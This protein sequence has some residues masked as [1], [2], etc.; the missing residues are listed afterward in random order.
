MRVLVGLPVL[1]PLLLW[2]AGDQQP[3]FRAGISLVRLDV[4]VLA[5]GRPLQGLTREDFEIVDN[6]VP[7][8][9]EEVLG[10]EV[11]LD[12]AFV[13]DRSESVKGETLARLKEAA[14]ATF[15][16]LGERDR[17]ALLTFSD[18]M[19]LDA[20]LGTSRAAFAKAL[21]EVRGGGAT[22]L[23]D[24]LY[25]AV[26]LTELE[27]RRTLILLF[28]D[29]YDNRSWLTSAQ[30]V[31]AAKESEAVISAVALRPT[32]RGWGDRATAPLIEVLK[33]VCDTT[34]GEVVAVERREALRTAFLKI[35]ENMRSRYLL[36][37]YPTGVER[38]GW[39]E[40]K[41]RLRNKRG[42]V[43]AR[44]GYSVPRG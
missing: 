3:T 16:G 23:F 37:Y 34:G 40:L 4:A 39:H 21:S 24:A 29:G 25:G 2:A 38:V 32:S 15:N 1:I 42:T 10:D 5:N 22:A 28:S 36:T 35:L 18:R 20:A 41:V 30:V 7:Q 13:I 17:A 31:Q 19:S 33:Q 6:G 44:P 9:L 11:P 43:I 8:R 14:Q 12:V 26:S 27:R